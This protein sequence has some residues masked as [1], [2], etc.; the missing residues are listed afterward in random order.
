MLL[1]AFHL[2][3]ELGVGVKEIAESLENWQPP[4][5]RGNFFFYRK[6]VVIDDSYNANPLSSHKALRFLNSLSSWDFET[7]G[8]WGDMLELGSATPRAHRQFLEELKKSSLSRVL[9]VGEEMKKGA[10]EVAKKEIEEGRFLLFS[11]SREVQEF[12]SCHLPRRERRVILFK[13]SRKLEL[14]KAIPP[15][16]RENYG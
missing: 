8:V 15:E 12:L 11:N 6:G 10:E 14:E 4:S 16:W 2:A 1:P 7:W 9:L 13:G 5:G 3:W